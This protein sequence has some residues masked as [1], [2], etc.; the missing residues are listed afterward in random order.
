MILYFENLPLERQAYYNRLT[1][2]VIEITHLAVDKADWEKV[3][4]CADMHK[5]I[6][7]CADCELDTP[8]HSY[9]WTSIKLI[10]DIIERFC[11]VDGFI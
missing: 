6:K 11:K 9:K 8:A 1:E 5:H 7:W 10:L 3:S 4:R 2:R